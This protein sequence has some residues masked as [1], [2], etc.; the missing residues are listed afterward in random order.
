M[1]ARTSLGD[2]SITMSNA[3]ADRLLL[4]SLRA[5]SSTEAAPG[6][7]V[8]SGGIPARAYTEDVGQSQH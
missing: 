3:G 4:P 5:V 8:A 7:M 6:E 1:P 2:L